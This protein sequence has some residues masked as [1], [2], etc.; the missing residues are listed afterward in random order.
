MPRESVFGY[1]VRFENASDADAPALD[2]VVTHELDEELDLDTF[3]LGDVGWA[4]VIVDVPS[5]LQEHEVVVDQDT[6]EHCDTGSAGYCVRFH[7]ALD[8]DT[9][10]VTWTWTTELAAGGPITDPFAGFLHPHVVEH[11]GAG[12]AHFT[13]R[14]LADS[15]AGPRAED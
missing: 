9:R 3:E 2:V 10:T 6:G 5:G 11:E 14:P 12:W 7:A 1:M 8:H 15:P 4:D 13:V